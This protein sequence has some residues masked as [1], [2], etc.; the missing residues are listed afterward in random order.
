M[1]TSTDN[2]AQ[3][4]TAYTAQVQMQALEALELLAHN[5]RNTRNREEAARLRKAIREIQQALL[6]LDRA[7][8]QLREAVRWA[9]LAREVA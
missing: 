2:T 3:P 6:T 4:T 7:E 1:T 8:G 9:N 5:E